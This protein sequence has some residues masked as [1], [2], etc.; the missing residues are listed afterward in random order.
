M[1][2][3]SRPHARTAAAFSLVECVIALGI[4]AVVILT[5][6]KIVPQT[7]DLQRIANDHSALAVVLRDVHHRIEGQA[8]REGPLP[9]GP[10]FYDENGAFFHSGEPGTNLNSPTGKMTSD[11]QRFFRAETSLHRIQK[12]PGP[13][14]AGSPSQDE[15]LWIVKLDLFW[16]LDQDGMPLGDSG[17]NTGLTWAVSALSG[18]DWEIID[19]AYHP[20][21]EY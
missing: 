20:K 8:L 9:I 19:P 13:E 17:P 11:P 4:A 7:L 10:L 18:P 12:E 21:L 3:S 2:P 5:L 1:N 16:P 15:G 6:L 14:G